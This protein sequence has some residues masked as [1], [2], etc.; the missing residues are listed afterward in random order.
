M[1]CSFRRSFHAA[2]LL[3]A[4]LSTGFVAAGDAAPSPR[5]NLLLAIADDWGFPHAGAYGDAVVKTPAFDR[6]A[7]EGV[8]FTNAYVSS[9]SCTPSRGALLTGQWH[10]RL[11][12]AANLWSVFPDSLVTYPEMLEK[13]GYAIGSTGKAWGPGRP[14]TP[15]RALGGPQYKNFQDFLARRAKDKPFCFWLGSS[16]PH[17]PYEKGSGAAAGIPLER[18]AL[19]ACFPDEPAIRADVA[20]YYFEVQRFDALVG[21]ALAALERAGE[22]DRTLVIVTSDNGM[23][24]PRCKS[25][26]YDTGVRM[27]FAVRWPALAK[28]GRRLE[29][30]VSLTD[31]APTFLEAAGLPV[32]AEMTGRSLLPLLR[33]E[34]SGRI[35]PARDCVLFGKER[36]VP[37]QERPDTGGYPCR[38]IR[39]HE[40]LYIRNF[41]P[42]RWPAGTPA[43]ERATIARAW[44]ADCD[45]GPTKS[46]MIEGREKDAAHRRLHDLAFAKRPAEELYDLRKDPDQLVNVAADPAYTD[47]RTKLA[48]RLTELLRTTADP[49]V[50]GGVEA[51]EREPYLGSAPEYEGKKN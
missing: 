2:A 14:Q 17:R 10:W 35:D 5:P 9:P 6:L 50:V 43:H 26:L 13:A 19:P 44:F 37:C 25:N 46:C 1:S 34:G 33:H 4:A 40:Y 49:R 8:L 20:D 15:K 31:I 18:I 23:P 28:G 38:A 30:F 32:P 48:A 11:K 3:V 29:D 12:G 42:E 45:N 27:P 51:F 39:T 16:D 7:R 41:T 22:L 47:A 36:H 21:A 24:F